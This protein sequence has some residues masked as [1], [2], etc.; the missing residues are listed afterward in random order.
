MEVAGV[1]TKTA[2]PCLLALVPLL[3]D[4]LTA[5]AKLE[6]MHAL[7]PLAAPFFGVQEG[8]AWRRNRNV[9]L[10]PHAHPTCSDVS[11]EAAVFLVLV[12]Q[13]LD[14]QQAKLY[15][16]KVRMVRHVLRTFPDALTRPRVLPIGRLD[17]LTPVAFSQQ[18]I[19]FRLP[20]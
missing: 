11:T 19:A 6:L 14:V 2:H 1:I 5:L 18:R 3:C 17:A 13:L 10:V 12:S 8:S 4:A 15:A 7:F 20:R 9:P 16:L